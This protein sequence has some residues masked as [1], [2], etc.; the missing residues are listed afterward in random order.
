MVKVSHRSRKTATRATGAFVG[1]LDMTRTS[2]S[3]KLPAA[4][5]L[6]SD[7]DGVM[8]IGRKDRLESHKSRYGGVLHQDSD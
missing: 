4:Y 6:K 7:T 1:G 8:L 5:S 2:R 3:L